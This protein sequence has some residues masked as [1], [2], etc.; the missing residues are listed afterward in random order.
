MNRTPYSRCVVCGVACTRHGD[1]PRC[2]AHRGRARAWWIAPLIVAACL[3]GCATPAE[4]Y[5]RA[6]AKTYNLVAPELLREPSR[7]TSGDPDA[8]DSGW[9][10]VVE[11]WRARIEEAALAAGLTL[12]LWSAPE[13]SRLPAT[14]PSRGAGA[15]D[16]DGSPEV[17]RVR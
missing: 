2:E 15:A 4:R 7:V 14:E 9:L 12:D 6:D 16:R 11:S 3:A 17:I 10:A 13:P 8:T 1:T 5:I